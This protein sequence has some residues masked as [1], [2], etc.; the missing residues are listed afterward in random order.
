MDKRLMGKGTKGDKEAG[1]VEEK[2]AGKGGE[3]MVKREQLVKKK[4]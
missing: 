3:K 1:R 4:K 2:K